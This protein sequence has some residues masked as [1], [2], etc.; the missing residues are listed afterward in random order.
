MA[1]IKLGERL[2]QLLANLITGDRVYIHDMAEECEASVKTIQRDLKCLSYFLPINTEKGYYW[3][4][5]ASKGQYN[6]QTV[7]SLIKTLGLA[8]EFPTLDSQI[9]SLLLLPEDECPFLIH[10]K[11]FEDNL[12]YQQTFKQLASAIAYRHVINFS[13]HDQNYDGVEPYKLVSSHEV[14]YLAMRHNDKLRYARV[15]EIKFVSLTPDRYM[16]DPSIA[17]QIAS[18]RFC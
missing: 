15:S 9:L 8:K 14:W 3:M 2:A 4:T 13:C 18:N 16:Y 11:A 10:P 6:Q 5:P 12:A 17:N 1:R 7:R